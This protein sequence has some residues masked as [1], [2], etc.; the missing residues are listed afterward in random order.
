[1]WPSVET[2]FSNRSSVLAHLSPWQPCALHGLPQ[3]A[4]LA[5]VGGSSSA[6]SARACNISGRDG[7]AGRYSDILQRILDSS[8]APALA[9]PTS[10]QRVTVS[11]LAHGGTDS[12]WNALVLD[13][14]VDAK[15]A[16]VLVWE[17]ATNDALGGKT[18]AFPRSADALARGLD[19]W[20]WRVTRHFKA[21]RRDVPPIVMVYL[22]DSNPGFSDQ[23]GGVTTRA[24]DAHAPV[25]AHYRRAG[26]RIATADVGGILREHRDSA[27]RALDDIHHPSCEMMHLIASVLA[28]VVVGGIASAAFRRRQCVAEAREARARASAVR[29]A[30]DR[31]RDT[32]GDLLRTLMSNEEVASLMEWEPQGGTTLFRLGDVGGAERA[33]EPTHS[34]RAYEGRA[35]RKTSYALP[36]CPANI[37]FTLLEP[38]LTWLGLGYGGGAF[39]RHMYSGRVRVAIN[40]VVGV[41]SLDASLNSSAAS[42]FFSLFPAQ[43]HP[44]QRGK[45]ASELIR[46]WIHIPSAVGRARSYVL[47]LCKDLG[48]DTDASRRAQ[49]LGDFRVGRPQLNWIIGV[50]PPPRDAPPTPP[51]PPS[52]TLRR[53]HTE[54]RPHV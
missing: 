45:P 5:I 22:W 37:T 38:A 1:M 25:V 29:P 31:G 19:L 39:E 32:R 7:G 42:D 23:L 34:A 51:H 43:T 30:M 3:H 14:L 15:R 47:S 10:R 40:G 9:S 41:R 16:D 53:N 24:F 17:Y 46:E 12:I 48:P 13:E 20:L 8:G 50:Q 44:F 52:P 18:G 28:Q 35:D 33:V 11:N 26:L 27:H 4:D 36:T 54:Q 6:H 2:N 49:R 21:A